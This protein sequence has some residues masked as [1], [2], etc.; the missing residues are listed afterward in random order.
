MIRHDYRFWEKKPN[1]SPR[2]SYKS[3]WVGCAFLKYF[4]EGNTEF[5]SW[6]YKVYF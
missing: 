3:D 6:V 2:F 1:R 4:N 5:F